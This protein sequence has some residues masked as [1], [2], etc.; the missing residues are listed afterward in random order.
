MKVALF[1]FALL[2]SVLVAKPDVLV[3]RNG[4]V[5][6]GKVLQQDPKGV[7]FQL[8]YGTF[9]YPKASFKQVQIDAAA[10]AG[11]SEST[12][13][14]N[15][16]AIITEFAKQKWATSVRQTPATVIDTGILKHVPYI[17]FQ[18]A[19]GGY[20]LNIYGDPDDP[21]GFELGVR[22]YLLDKAEA[23]SNCVA[24][25]SLLLNDEAEGTIV[26]QLNWAK[27]SSSEDGVTF[28]ITPPSDPDAY[29]GWWISIYSEAML[30][31]MRAS[32][33]ELNVISH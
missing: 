28:E 30:D 7:L 25:V 5:L 19:S 10:N 2:L 8:E 27:D 14:P 1:P 18:A 4:Q 3:L 26:R 33:S 15:W 9:N 22:S 16:G 31:A 32:D 23:K 12:L 24:F 6:N 29:G 20:E 21:A 13:F 11:N 17:S